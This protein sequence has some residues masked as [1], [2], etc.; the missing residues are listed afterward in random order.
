M[1]KSF[2]FFVWSV[3]LA[4]PVAGEPCSVLVMD[5]G[6]RGRGARVDGAGVGDELSARLV[7]QRMT[8]VER[9]ELMADLPARHVKP[10]W[11]ADTSPVLTV[12]RTR[13]VDVVVSGTVIH[14]GN[15][16][17]LYANVIS[18]HNGLAFEESVTG[19]AT[20][21]LDGPQ[22]RL[23]EQIK[24][25]INAEHDRLLDTSFSLTR[26]TREEVSP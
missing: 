25:R 12:C 15:R 17:H 9:D 16:L 20:R 1:S 22:K 5:F 18:A 19:P 6:Q 21:G 26:E 10:L 14:D 7:A 8:V 11:G 3:L 23:A 13:G 24:R 2:L 4:G